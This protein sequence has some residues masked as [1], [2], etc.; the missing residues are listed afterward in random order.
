ML[1]LMLFFM[2]LF[3]LSVHLSNIIFVSNLHAQSGWTKK[4]EGRF[5]SFS[6]PSAY[7]LYKLKLSG[8]LLLQ[9]QFRLFNKSR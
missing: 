3:M 8:F 1:F 7:F 5:I 4:V 9:I 2:L 6:S